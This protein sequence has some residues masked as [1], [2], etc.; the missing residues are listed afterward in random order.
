MFAHVKTKQ[1][2]VTFSIYQYYFLPTDHWIF[3][4]TCTQS[5]DVKYQWN[6]E[7]NW[8]QCVDSYTAAWSTVT[9]LLQEEN[10]SDPSVNNYC[11][12][13]FSTWC[14]KIINL[15]STSLE[16]F[17]LFLFKSEINEHTA[18]KE[19]DDWIKNKWGEMDLDG[20]N[21]LSQAES[22]TC[23]HTHHI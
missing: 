4:V 18:Q 12:Q 17:I 9:G 22:C 15:T 21:L 10:D 5:C 7:I 3:T 23:M 2:A 14:P 16:G 13:L 19:M 1:L 11:N 8:I 6:I 20:V